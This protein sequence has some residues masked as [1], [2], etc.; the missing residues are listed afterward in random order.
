MDDRLRVLVAAYAC[1]PVRGSEAGV[2]WGWVK[3]LARFH[4]LWVLTD[5]NFRDEIESE[6]ANNPG[7]ARHITFHYIPR[8][9]AML[10]ER[11]WEPAYLWTYK[12]QWQREAYYLAR[13]LHSE[14]GF[15]IVHQLTYVGFRVPGYLWKLGIPFVWGPLGGLEQLP[16]RLFG[17]LERRGQTYYFCRNLWNE[18]DRRYAPSPRRA[19][20]KAS[21]LIA[22]T[23]G[24]REA[25]QRFYDRD[26]SV[27]CEIGAPP[28]SVSR[29]CPRSPE[30]PL[31]L[32]WSGNHNPGKV[33]P[34]L[35]RAFAGVPARVDWRLTV[36]GAGPCTSGWR[37]LSAR[38]GLESRCEWLGQI[39]RVQALA[40]MQSAHVLVITSL[41]DLTSTVLVEALA[42]GVPVICPNLYGFR[43]ALTPQCGFRLAPASPADLVAGIARAIVELHDSEEL[44]Y[45]MALAALSRSKE[46]SWEKKAEAVDRIYRAAA[47]RIS[48]PEPV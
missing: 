11:F 39:P 22:A 7:L 44:R 23:S 16:W 21:A 27:I 34:I 36:L 12:Y 35:L 20:A 1:S 29:P 13:R 41:Y 10:L 30:E 19:F 25:I 28:V 24:I 2:G 15:D 5:A 47:N 38:L 48:V 18:F 17:A 32:L 31:R 26:S 6:L 40:V 33:L 42:N 14:I 9:R 3:A 37:R 4:D 46:F 45:R 8:Y 43:D